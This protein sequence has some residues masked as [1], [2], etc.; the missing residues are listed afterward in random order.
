[1]HLK[2]LL[3]IALSTPTALAAVNEPCYGT[4]SVAGVCLATADCTAAGGSNIAGACPA[5]AAGIRCCFKTPCANGA[6]G[7]CRWTS[8]CAGTTVANQCPGPSGM[9]CC[10]SSATGFGGYSAPTMP[11]VGA[12][13]AV[14]V[15]GAT[16]V[17]AAWPGRVREIGCVRSCAC[18]GTS[19]HCCGKAV[20]LMCSDAGGTPT[21]SGREIA[22]WVMNHR[23]TLNLKYVIWGQRIWNPSVDSVLA[24]TSWRSMDD[25]GDV[26]QNHW[27]HVHVS[28]D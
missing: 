11:A 19:D 1:M 2:T 22:E 18:P 14:A 13:Q 4:G 23:S 12:C 15:S 6:S 10:S 24:W 20:D 17:V 25:R 28:F 26:T 3:L 16:A 21:I 27:D 5:D 8:D 9:K 7:N